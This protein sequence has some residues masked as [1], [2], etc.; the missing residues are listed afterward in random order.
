[1]GLDFQPKNETVG[2]ILMLDTLVNFCANS[3]TFCHYC[4]F[5]LVSQTHKFYKCIIP[6]RMLK[7]CRLEA[8]QCQQLM[9]VEQM[10]RDLADLLAISSH[11]SQTIFEH[12]MLTS[13]LVN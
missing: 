11:N 5:T 12:S 3:T 4:A 13:I 9:T 10:K 2:L 6:T 8:A 1:M 7:S